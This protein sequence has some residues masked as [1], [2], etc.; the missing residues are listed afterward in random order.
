MLQVVRDF[1]DSYDGIESYESRSRSLWMQ[2][3]LYFLALPQWH[4]SLRES[5]VSFIPSPFA[6]K[7]ALRRE[8]LPGSVTRGGAEFQICLARR[9]SASRFANITAGQSRGLTGGEPP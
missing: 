5:F 9:Q 3:F 8:L 1:R 6:Q 2:Q 7:V 4:K